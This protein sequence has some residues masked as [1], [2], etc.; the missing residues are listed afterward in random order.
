MFE[1]LTLIFFIFVLLLASFLSQKVTTVTTTIMTG[2]TGYEIVSSKK[3]VSGD[4]A[5]LKVSF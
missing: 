2:S 3:S 4:E 5:A 1:C